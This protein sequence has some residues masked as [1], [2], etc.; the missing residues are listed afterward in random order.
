M[1]PHDTR[2][3][4]VGID[5]AQDALANDGVILHETSLLKRQWAFLTQEAGGQA[6]LADVMH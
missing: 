5:L 1:M 2:D 3:V 4:V 6:N